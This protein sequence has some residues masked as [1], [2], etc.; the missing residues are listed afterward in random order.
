MGG[1]PQWLLTSTIL[2]MGEVRKDTR[3]ERTVVKVLP[4]HLSSSPEARQRFERG[5]K[6]ISQLSH[7]HICAL[8]DV[9]NQDGIEYLVMEYLEGETHASVS[10]FSRSLRSGP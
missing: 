10:P 8:Y 5:A 7:P 9:D 1:F 6:T 4:Q 3:L 2:T